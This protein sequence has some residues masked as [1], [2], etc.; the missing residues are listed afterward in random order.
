MYS[1]V[2]AYSTQIQK[3]FLSLGNCCIAQQAISFKFNS[4]LYYLYSIWIN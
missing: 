3:L 1:V 4:M 2:I